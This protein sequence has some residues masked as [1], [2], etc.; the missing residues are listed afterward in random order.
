MHKLFILLSTKIFSRRQTLFVFI[1]LASTFSC[2]KIEQYSLPDHSPEN[3]AKPGENIRPN[4]LF[5][6]TD[7]IGYEV[8][9]Y[10]GGL[11]YKTPYID[12]LAKT[13]RQF[14]NCYASPMCSPSRFALTTGKYNF[15]N[16]PKWGRMNPTEK[17][18][19]N[20]LSDAG[21]NTFYTGKWQFD[22]GDMSITNFGWQN[23]CVWLPYFQKDER[24]EG[25]RYKSPKIYKQGAYLHDSLTLNKY[26]EDIFQ[27]ELIHFLN[28]SATKQ[29]PFMAFYS[30]NLAHAPFCPPPT[31]PAYAT[32]N[33]ENFAT[34]KKYF[35]PMVNYMD[36][37][38]GEVIQTLENNG[39]IDN[40]IIIFTS[41]NGS[42]PEIY[43]NYKGLTVK[44][45]KKSTTENGTSVPMIVSWKGVIAPG[46]STSDL[47]EFTDFLPTLVQLAGASIPSDFGIVDGHSFYNSLFTEADSTAR[48]Y[49]YNAYA[50]NPDR[51]KYY[52][53][54]AQNAQYKLY[55]TNKV[56]PV[57]KL[58][59]V[60]RCKP[61]V[62]LQDL[63]LTPEELVIKDEL[64]QVLRTYH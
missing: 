51:Q 8:P 38:I 32:W 30:M 39:L 49:I 16:Y 60:E 28:D 4:I 53:R 13:G 63:L 35:A 20:I 46:S 24:L 47:V 17:T 57:Y 31:H 43:S 62:V 27:Q 7:D 61:D 64:T 21:Y 44:G 18:V 22:G 55:D 40:T 15:R 56:T 50:S 12:K 48:K 54:W 41:D 52:E 59:K 23:Y 2:T 45:G 36:K 5:I 26:S 29:N 19:A 58:V 42:P 1:L 34:A 37:K 14:T 10:T 25:S 11:S 6:L 9:G 3:F 33:F